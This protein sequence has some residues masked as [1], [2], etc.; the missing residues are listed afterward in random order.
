LTLFIKNALKEDIGKA[1]ITTRLAIPK[2]KK[3]EAIIVAKEN[4]VICGIDIAG[5][6]FKAI[7]KNIKFKPFIS[8][9]DEVRKGK[10]LARIFGDAARILTAERVALN[11]LSMLSGIATKTSLF[12]KRVKPYKSK[13]LDT[14][15]TLPGLRSLEKY[16]VR[17]GGGY[18]HR[19]RLDEMVLIKD[20]HIR[21]MGYGLWVMG[22]KERIKKIKKVIHKKMKIEVEVKNLKEFK[23]VLETE[24]DII[25][26]DNMKIDDVKKAVI[27]M[28]K[29]QGAKCKTQIEVS[30]N[31]ALNTVKKYAACG[32]GF[33]SVGSLTKDIDSLDISL[34]IL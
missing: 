33:I 23:E 26:L 19:F 30:G 22:L 4:G 27:V 17:V 20:N 18:N 12:L 6:V 5:L 1:D 32:V 15:K 31:I 34:D 7:D 11:F 14:R 13:I 24:P 28:R 10:I 9:G 21:V 16:A 3:T 29:T 2:G 25:M 8:D